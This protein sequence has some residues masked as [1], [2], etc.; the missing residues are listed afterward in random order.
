MISS[1]YLS[2][3]SLFNVNNYVINKEIIKLTKEFSNYEYKIKYEQFFCKLNKPFLIV[4]NLLNYK[5]EFLRVINSNFWDEFNLEI[6]ELNLYNTKI[7][8]IPIEIK[9]LTNLQSLHLDSNKIRVIPTEIQFL[10][11]LQ[12]LYL[13]HNKITEISEE[14]Q[15]LT[16]LKYLSLSNNQITV[17]PIKLKYLTN[18]IYLYLYYNKIKTIP[19]ELKEMKDIIYLHE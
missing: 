12:Y 7:K 6:T 15:F 9:F 19:E 14:M 8:E 3:I 10:T 5:T 13:D 18:L 4:S 17:I 2:L 1:Y 11:N 16:N